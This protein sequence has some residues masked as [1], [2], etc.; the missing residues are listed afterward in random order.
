[1]GIGGEVFRTGLDT[2]QREPGSYFEKMFR[3]NV[4][5]DEK[6][7]Y[8]IDRD[9]TNFR[10]VL[11]FLRRTLDPTTLSNNELRELYNEAIYYKLEGLMELLKPKYNWLINQGTRARW[12]DSFPEPMPRET[13]LYLSRKR[14]RSI[15][16]ER[17]DPDGACITLD[18]G[19]KRFKVSLKRLDEVSASRLPSMYSSGAFTKD[20]E[21]E[22]TYFIDRDG[23]NFHHIVNF[24]RGVFDG[25]ILSN[26]TLW[27]LYTEAHFYE[28]N[29]LLELLRPKY[30]K[31]PF[32]SKN[33]PTGVL[34]W[35]AT[36][37]GTRAQW[38]D[39]ISEH[40][41]IT[42]S[43]GFDNGNEFGPL[44]FVDP[45]SYKCGGK[46]YSTR[47]HRISVQLL[48]YLVRPTHYRLSFPR[49]GK[50]NRRPSLTWK[51]EGA[52]DE[53]QWTL[54]RKH[55]DPGLVLKDDCAWEVKSTEKFFRYFRLTYTSTT[56]SSPD[57]DRY[58]FHVCGFDLYGTLRDAYPEQAQ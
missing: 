31:F 45:N 10:H 36:N 49:N 32:K 51:L 54:L 40:V 39:S 19:G 6:G 15:A 26:D 11:N 14:P 56:S 2:L 48:K 46:C 47:Y 5:P 23:T 44:N 1:M 58:C 9:G 41:V 16:W 28:I 53:G 20:P 22:Y 50:C 7:V 18:V 24:L 21:D 55:T 42:S 12:H 3:N 35:L 37:K 8:F 4:E 38:H 52:L 43:H 13:K 27:Q 17:E 33:D 57:K 25:T 29:G 34:Y 30:K